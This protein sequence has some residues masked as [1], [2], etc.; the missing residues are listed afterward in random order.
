MQLLDLLAD[1][2]YSLDVS[3]LVVG[4]S[5]VMVALHFGVPAL[6]ATVSA[7]AVMLVVAWALHVAVE[8]PSHQ[9]GH[10]W[11]PAVV[12]R[13]QRIGHRW[14]CHRVTRAPHRAER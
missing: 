3:D 6:L 12:T 14:K 1:I 8:R 13:H 7:Q 9:L 2:S 10:R 5:V 4:T 11:S